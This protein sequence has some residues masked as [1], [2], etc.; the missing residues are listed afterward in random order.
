MRGYLRLDVLPDIEGI[1]ETG[2]EN[3]R[4]RAATYDV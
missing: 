4:A 2:L 1:S 3:D